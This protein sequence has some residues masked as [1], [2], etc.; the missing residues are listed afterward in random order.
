AGIGEV[1]DRDSR[2]ADAR[3]DEGRDVPPGAE[4]D[5]A[6]G[7]E[8]PFRFGCGVVVCADETNERTNSRYDVE[9]RKAGVA[10]V[11]TGEVNPEPV[12]ELIA[13][14]D[15]VDPAGAEAAGLRNKNVVV[16][17]RIGIENV[18]DG[19]IAEADV[20]AQIPAA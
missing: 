8:Q 1:C 12:V 10:P 14:A 5:I 18:V 3:A 6:V 20:A 11:L 15:V 4:I 19:L 16:G 9:T 7:K 13:K 2:G 17:G